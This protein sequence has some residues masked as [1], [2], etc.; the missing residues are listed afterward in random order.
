MICLQ[1][2]NVMWWATNSRHPWVGLFNAK[3]P[4][5]KYRKSWQ[6]A[7]YLIMRLSVLERW[8]FWYVNGSHCLVKTHLSLFMF[9]SYFPLH[10]WY[11][12]LHPYNPSNQATGIS[13]STDVSSLV[14]IQ[15]ILR[16]NCVCFNI[17]TAFRD[18][19]NPIKSVNSTFMDKFSSTLQK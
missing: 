3:I 9:F 18:M 6:T 15:N 11:C 7:L 14:D 8:H 12:V 13:D 5:Y 16:G 17:Q 4:S 1:M 19:E 10:I 2:F